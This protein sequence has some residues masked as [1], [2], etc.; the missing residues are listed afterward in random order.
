MVDGSRSVSGRDPGSAEAF[1]T[2]GTG[3]HQGIGEVIQ[4]YSYWCHEHSGLGLVGHSSPRSSVRLFWFPTLW[5]A[6]HIPT[7][8]QAAHIP[9]PRQAAHFP[10]LAHLLRRSRRRRANL[11]HPDCSA[12]P[13]P[14]PGRQLNWA[15]PRRLLPRRLTSRSPTQLAAIR[16]HRSE[17]SPGPTEINY[18]SRRMGRFAR[19]QAQSVTTRDRIRSPVAP[20]KYTGETGSGFFVSAV[21]F[22]SSLTGGMSY[23]LYTGKPCPPV[24]AKYCRPITASDQPA[25]SHL[26]G[27]FGPDWP[28]QGRL[29]LD[30][31]RT[32]NRSFCPRR[33]L[34]HD[35]VTH[36]PIRILPVPRSAP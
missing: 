19:L 15:S 30:W 6:A 26:T 29:P 14:D 11:R 28:I 18:S 32:I 21:T 4:C 24:I 5:P 35:I 16:T 31:P 10:S 8:R 33:P 36:A 20:G 27:A 9:T 3:S 13:R 12:R 23:E 2:V 25:L 17:R 7:L 1:H 22:N 34:W